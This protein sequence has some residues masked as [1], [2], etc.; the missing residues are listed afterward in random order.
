MSRHIVKNVFCMMATNAAIY[1]PTDPP[2]KSPFGLPAFTPNVYVSK[3]TRIIGGTSAVPYSYPWIVRITN[4]DANNCNVCGG[5]LLPPDLDNNSQ[6]TS[7]DLV[8]TAAHC[9]VTDSNVLVQPS[10][11]ILKFGNHR[12][13]LVEAHEYYVKA[14]RIVTIQG[15]DRQTLLDDIAIIQLAKTVTFNKFI[16]AIRL[17]SKDYPSN[18]ALCVAAGWGSYFED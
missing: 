13:D 10:Q 1:R 17:P 3:F 9:V 15:F 7:S 11:I 8:V 4:C 16:N 12:D 6:K 2:F 18:P 5:T 14:R